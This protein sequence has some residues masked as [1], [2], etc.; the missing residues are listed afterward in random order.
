MISLAVL[1]RF[2]LYTLETKKLS[3]GGRSNKMEGMEWRKQA[4][5]SKIQQ[6]QTEL[7]KL[8]QPSYGQS[9]VYTAKGIGS[10]VHPDRYDSKLQ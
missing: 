6:L 10:Q 3:N 5:I 8:R 7:D 1:A 4:L 9:L 2:L